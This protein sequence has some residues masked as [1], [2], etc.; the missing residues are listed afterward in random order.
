MGLSSQIPKQTK[1]YAGEAVYFSQQEE[2]VLYNISAIPC[3]GVAR[4]IREPRQT[5][6]FFLQRKILLI[7]IH[8]QHRCQLARDVRGSKDA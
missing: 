4:N 5:A 3:S 2:C 6:E 1:P 8:K 7:N